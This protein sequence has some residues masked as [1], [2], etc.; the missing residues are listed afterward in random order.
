M[1][2]KADLFPYPVLYS[3]TDDY[4]DSYFYTEMT[5]TIQT[6]T[7][8]GLKIDFHIKNPEIER[9]LNEGSFSFAV[10][11]EGVSSS[12]RKLEV[13][14][15]GDDT[16]TILLSSDYISS[17]VEVNTMIIAEKDISNYT[18]NDFNP[19]YYEEGY[20]VHSIKKGDII[21]YDKMSELR[22]D[23][24]NKESPNA[25]SMI[26][27]SAKSQKYMSIDIDGDFIQVFLPEK[28]HSAYIAL[29]S[30]NEIRKNLLLITIVQQTL[31]YVIEQI[32]SHAVPDENLQWYIALNS[33]LE[34]LGYDERSLETSDSL[35]LAQ[36][37]LDMPLENAL[38]N[39]YEWGEFDE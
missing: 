29:S 28:A 30:S 22:V 12:Y 6:L 23:F 35:K 15:V 8:I 13:L 34:N 38:Y 5:K 9:R 4:I 32:K 3:E 10:H 1:K 2:L 14:P 39:Y 31:V 25:K 19:D 7:Q 27:V 16:I 33:L 11:L 20:V 36:E 21:A 18:N 26:R 24:E 17:K 37:L